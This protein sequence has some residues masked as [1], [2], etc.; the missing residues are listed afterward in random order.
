MTETTTVKISIDPRS[1]TR[2][3]RL[4]PSTASGRPT[5]SQMLCGA[6]EAGLYRLG[7]SI[8]IRDPQGVPWA[9]EILRAGQFF[10]IR[11]LEVD[12]IRWPHL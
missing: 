12:G 5:H 1:R 7:H 9:Q 6:F 4:A 10:W 3:L 2:P 11:H 8:R